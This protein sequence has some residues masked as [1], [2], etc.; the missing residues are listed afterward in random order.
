MV[1]ENT[2]APAEVVDCSDRH[3]SKYYLVMVPYTAPLSAEKAKKW[4]YDHN[5]GK[6]PKSRINLRLCPEEVSAQLTG[7]VDPNQPIDTN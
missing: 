7:C 4:L 6:Y 1:M 3:F 5:N 2:K